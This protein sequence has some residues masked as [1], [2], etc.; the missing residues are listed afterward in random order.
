MLYQLDIDE[1]LLE[2]KENP[3]FKYVNIHTFNI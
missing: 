1:I 3:R 2:I